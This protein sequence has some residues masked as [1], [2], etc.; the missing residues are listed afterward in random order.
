MENAKVE[1]P[2]CLGK[3]VLSRFIDSDEWSV[4]TS[5]YVCRT[6]K[7]TGTIEPKEDTD[8]R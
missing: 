8:E 6:C 4:H 3:R 5:I 1:C 2:E 7:G